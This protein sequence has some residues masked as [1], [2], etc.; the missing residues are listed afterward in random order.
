[1][2]DQPNALE[3]ALD[4]L[5]TALSGWDPD[6]RPELQGSTAALRELLVCFD[7][8]KE[9]VAASL[10]SV[11]L[12]LLESIEEHGNVRSEVAVGAVQELSRGL[13]DA[14][15]HRLEQA[16]VHAGAHGDEVVLSLSSAP[17]A[18]ISLALGEVDQPIGQVLVKMGVLNEEQVE[19]VLQRQAEQSEEE[20]Q[21]FGEIAVALGYVG[22]SHVEQALRLQARGRGAEPAPLAERDPW[23]GSPL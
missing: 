5:T 17:S 22:E 11:G 6:V 10:C 7:P 4:A 20:R 12:T 2:S 16:P 14:L 1:M 13:R 8:R 19:L 18:G 21:R 3:T 23:G 9:R 15:A